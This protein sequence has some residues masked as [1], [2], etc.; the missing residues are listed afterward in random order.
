[1]P[2]CLTPRPPRSGGRRWPAVASDHSSLS[3][4]APDLLGVRGRAAGRR[5]AARDGSS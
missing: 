3:S 2:I 5:T 1:M 4:M